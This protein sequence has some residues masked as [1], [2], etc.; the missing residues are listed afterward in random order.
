MYG[1][2]ASYPSTVPA[3]RMLVS[4]GVETELLVGAALAQQVPVTVELDLDGAQALALLVGE[5]LMTL[6]GTQQLVLFSD[7]RLDVILEPVDGGICR[8]SSS[9]GT[10]LQPCSLR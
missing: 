3:S 1:G 8:S 5:P 7:E 2:Q 6:P 4:S 10:W 9:A